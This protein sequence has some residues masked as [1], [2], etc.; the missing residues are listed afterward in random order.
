MFKPSLQPIKIN[1]KPTDYHAI[2]A[3]IKKGDPAFVMSRSQLADYGRCAR[4]WIR[5]VK[6]DSTKA[7]D[8]GSMMDTMLFTP[9][10][11]ERVFSIAPA[12]YPVA[13]PTAKDPRTEKPW[14]MKASY[15][16]EWAEA[17]EAAGKTVISEET[18]RRGGE[19]LEILMADDVIREVRKNSDV[20]VQALVEWH[21]PHTGLVIPVKVLLD[22][23]GHPNGPYGSL[24]SDF[25]TTNDAS[26]DEWVKAVFNQEHYYQA[27]FYLDAY[28]A[29]TGLTYDMFANLVQE[30]AYPYETARRLIDDT[31]VELGRQRY[32]SDFLRYCMSLKENLWPGY[33]ETDLNNEIHPVQDGFR[34]VQPAKWML[35]KTSY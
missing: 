35:L 7:M 17:E 30:S 24:L 12:T 22:M 33:D 15:C 26:P 20:Q 14:T 32:R 13:K 16:Q 10:E 8:W 34:L 19:A 2:G 29:A 3:E 27:A 4:K 23:A 1:T 9:D 11:F 31:F 5:S 28:N 25:K 6:R 21:C 18:S